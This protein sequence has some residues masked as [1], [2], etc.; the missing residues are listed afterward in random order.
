MHIAN[1]RN[2]YRYS[3]ARTKRLVSV[4][5]Q[6]RKTLEEPIGGDSGCGRQ[7]ILEIVINASINKLGSGNSVC[8]RGGRFKNFCGVTVAIAIKQDINGILKVLLCNIVRY[9]GYELAHEVNAPEHECFIC[10]LNRATFFE[11][12]DCALSCRQLRKREVGTF[13]D[14]EFLDVG[15]ICGG[16][17]VEC[18]VLYDGR[19]HAY[20]AAHNILHN[21]GCQ[22]RFAELR[23]PIS[24][25]K[26]LV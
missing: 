10:S 8:C 18:C 5:C 9:C 21:V 20:F 26:E 24:G 14:A 2:G 1:L 3:A 15:L 19:R 13:L 25:E 23:F 16:K 6:S 22:E 11:Q 12:V 7:F 4:I 17:E